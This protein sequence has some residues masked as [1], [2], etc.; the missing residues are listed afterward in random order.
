MLKVSTFRHTYSFPSICTR[1]S[2]H[3]G[4]FDVV[5][6]PHYSD[7]DRLRNYFFCSNLLF[8]FAC[9]PLTTLDLR[10]GQRTYRF[11]SFSSHL[12]SR[13]VGDSSLIL[14]LVDLR[15]R[16]CG[17]CHPFDFG[18]SPQLIHHTTPSQ[19]SS[20]PHLI[21][22]HYILLPTYY[23]V[24]HSN[25]GQQPLP[26]PIPPSLHP[27]KSLHEPRPLPT[28]SITPTLQTVSVRSGMGDN[29]LHRTIL[30]G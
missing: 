6:S 27:T 7:E 16:F 12:S 2:Q 24:Y 8:P 3:P 19:T 29:L 13:G 21:P 10:S 20:K 25:S 18:T 5:L 23:P 1:P 17:N 14:W 22:S 4:W 15:I 30:R 11:F 9:H 26:H 28:H